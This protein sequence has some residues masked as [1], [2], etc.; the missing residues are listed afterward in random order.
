[1]RKLALLLF[2][3][4]YT[5]LPSA[6]QIKLS[7]LSLKDTSMS[8]LYLYAD[9][10]VKIEGFKAGDKVL[11]GSNVVKS[12][13]GNIY[14]LSPVSTAD[15]VLTVRNKNNVILTKAF[16]VRKFPDVSVHLD[17]VHGAYATVEAILAAPKLVVETGNFKGAFKILAFD[18]GIKSGNDFEATPTMLGSRLSLYQIDRI[19]RLKS[20]DKLFFENIR[21]TCPSCAIRLLMP[22]TL[23][24]Q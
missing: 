21:A 22:F 2:L 9:N 7:I 15:S 11:F 16:T 17:T 19:R 24:I 12:T 6:A 3:P 4:I 20:G 5:G 18:L 8:D 23:I 13:D 10:K 1:M 14:T